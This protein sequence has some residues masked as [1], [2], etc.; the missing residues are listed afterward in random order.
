MGQIIN[1][2]IPEYYSHKKY[3]E[4]TFQNWDIAL[5]G[6]DIPQNQLKN[7]MKWLKA[8]EEEA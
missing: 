7:F 8:R 5:C 2:T 1:P 6:L 4:D 3:D